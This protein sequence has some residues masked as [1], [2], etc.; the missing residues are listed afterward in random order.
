MIIILS[1]SKEDLVQFVEGDRETLKE[2][3]WTACEIL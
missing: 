1:S 2:N 3:V